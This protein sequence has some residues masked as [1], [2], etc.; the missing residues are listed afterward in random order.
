[1]MMTMT[2][3]MKM[4]TTISKAESLLKGGRKAVPEGIQKK[5]GV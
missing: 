1:M 4:M 5:K 3:K 2:R